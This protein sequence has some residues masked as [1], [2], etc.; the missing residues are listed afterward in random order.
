MLLRLTGINCSPEALQFCYW[1]LPSIYQFVCTPW[2]SVW[3]PPQSQ[4]GS[5]SKH[6][7]QVV[8]SSWAGAEDLKKVEE[9]LDAS[10]DPSSGSSRWKTSSSSPSSQTQG[11]YEDASQKA[12]ALAQMSQTGSWRR[13]MTAQVGITPPRTKGTSAALK[14]PGRRG[15]LPSLSR[16]DFGSRAIIQSDYRLGQN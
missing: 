4:K 13:G 15:S 8:S 9:E 11:Q 14:T 2:F 7:E 6:A 12:A 3:Q 10:M 5:R 1:I 16:S